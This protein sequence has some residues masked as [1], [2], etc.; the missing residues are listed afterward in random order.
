MKRLF[1]IAIL[2]VAFGFT[3]FTPF[4]LL[5]KSGNEIT[6]SASANDLLSAAFKNH[7]SDVQVQ[8]KGRV[9]KILPDDTKGS[10]H[11]R[12]ILKMASGQT[13]LVAHNI[14]LSDRVAGLRVGDT[15]AFYGEYEWNAKGGVLHWTH[16]D[17]R[18][19]HIDGWLKH[20]EVTYE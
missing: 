8:G 3:G 2:L 18:G 4:I 16:R 15:V 5:T 13:V 9:V 6:N 1:F 10:K 19:R 12:F 14:D 7:Q 17:P 20:K 11:Q